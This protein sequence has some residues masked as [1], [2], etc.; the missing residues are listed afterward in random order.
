VLALLTGL[1]ASGVTIVIITHDQHIAG[2]LPRQIQM[3]DG[4]IITDTTRATPAPPPGGA[5][6]PPPMA[7]VPWPAP[8]RAS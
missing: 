3:L 2:R 4:Q 6:G 8:G 7:A 1:N 5:A